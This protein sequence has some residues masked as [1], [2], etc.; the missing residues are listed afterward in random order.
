MTEKSN[1]RSPRDPKKLPGPSSLARRI[2]ALRRRRTVRELAGAARRL[3]V[4]AWIVGGAVRDLWLD[5]PVL[6]VDV[7]VAGD[8]EPLARELERRGVGR[9]VALSQAPTQVFRLAGRGTELDLAQ[10][11]RGSIEADL[12][13][14]DFTVN[15]IAL[16]LSGGPPV[17]PF[18]GVRDLA[19]RRL[20]AVAE[21]NFED[22]PLR[23]LRAARLLATHGLVADRALQGICR[24]A[25]PGLASVAPERIRAELA[26]LL[27]APRAAPA[28][29]W[30]ARA[31][32]LWPALGV[33]A[34]LPARRK[35][36]RGC[37][38]FDA[39]AFAR[40]S[41]DRRRQGR[42][43]LLAAM[44]GLSAGQAARWLAG[45]RWSREDAGAAARLLKL[46]R[47]AGAVRTADDQWRWLRDAGP[48]APEALA[49]IAG[50]GAEGRRGSRRL[51]R[52]LAAARRGPRVRGSDV[53]AWLDLPP[54]P[55]VGTLLGELEIAGL[56]GRVRTRAQARKWLVAQAPAIIRSS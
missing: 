6:D 28:L 17:D 4:D 30:A 42:L 8:A 52:R 31:D 53:L 10:L 36:A 44:L 54:G 39:P 5:R 21:K 49:V 40:L 51:R 15:A 55:Q 48:K 23:A 9:L 19:R 12:G 38:A 35:L 1:A 27:E 34:P 41:P 47:A 18:G 22:D 50:L 32:L 13:R 3:G 14:R 29:T 24:R 33:D 56:S 16:P 26:K 45:R 37:L 20:R 46:A 43:A 7:A 2:G 11:E 25:A